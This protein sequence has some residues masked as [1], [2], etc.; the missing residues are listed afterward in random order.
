M[1]IGNDGGVVSS[2]LES[3]QTHELLLYFFKKMC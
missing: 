1:V 3:G 2:Y